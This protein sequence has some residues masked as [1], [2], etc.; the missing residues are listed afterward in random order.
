MECATQKGALLWSKLCDR[1]VFSEI[2]QQDGI[3]IDKKSCNGVNV[4]RNILEVSWNN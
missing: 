4:E 1:V 2:M 3:T